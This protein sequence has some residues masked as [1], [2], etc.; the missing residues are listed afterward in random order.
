[1]GGDRLQALRQAILQILA[2]RPTGLTVPELEDK[3]RMQ[4]IQFWP[5]EVQ[6]VAWRLTAARNIQIA[7][8]GMISG[9]MST[10]DLVKNGNG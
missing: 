8:S 1:M 7:A 2:E 3:L 6:E 5:G 10:P 4:K 9:A